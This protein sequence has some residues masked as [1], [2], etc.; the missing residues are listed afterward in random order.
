M[1][2][3]IKLTAFILLI[4]GTIGL[5]VN[6]FAADCGRATTLVFAVFN[7]LGLAI[8]AVTYFDEKGGQ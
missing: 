3:A 1:S 7:C 2:K 4:I 5:L 8:L 6:E